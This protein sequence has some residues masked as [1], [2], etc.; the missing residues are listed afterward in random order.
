MGEGRRGGGRFT[1]REGGMGNEGSPLH[2]VCVCV[3]VYVCLYCVQLQHYEDS[4]T[5]T[6]SVHAGLF[7]CFHNPWNSDMD[8]GIFN[9]YTDLF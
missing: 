8:L 4:D 5:F 9:V 2:Y 1:A 6:V 7:W 3:C